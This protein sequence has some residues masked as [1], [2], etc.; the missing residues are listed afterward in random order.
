MA[1]ESGRPA[2]RE[3]LLRLMAR[4]APLPGLGMTSLVLGVVGLML[5]FM[6]ILGGPISALGLAFGILGTI[7]A[8]LGW[9]EA[10]LRWGLGGI[11]LCALSLAVNIAIWYAPGGYLPSR[12]VPQPWQPVNDR[13]WVSP[14]EM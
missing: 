2:M 13:P 3:N 5:F 8:L 12:S 7:S 1:S 6:P 9:G 4:H 11:A 10:S 14:P